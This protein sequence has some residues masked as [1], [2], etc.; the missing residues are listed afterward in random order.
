MRHWLAS[1]PG[2]SRPNATFPTAQPCIRI[3]A[4]PFDSKEPEL[5]VGLLEN[6]SLPN[7]FVSE[8]VERDAKSMRLQALSLC[9]PPQPDQGRALLIS[10]LSVCRSP[11]AVPETNTS[12]SGGPELR[13][14]LPMARPLPPTSLRPCYETIF[15]RSAQSIYYYKQK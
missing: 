2:G 12:S 10:K 15:S 11:R 7:V 6:E 14:K 1:H 4:P 8:F 5:A 9:S 13:S 3:E